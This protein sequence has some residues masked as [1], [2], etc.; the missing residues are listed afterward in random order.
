MVR[1]ELCYQDWIDLNGSKNGFLLKRLHE[2]LGQSQCRNPYRAKR[3]R[4]SRA[5]MLSCSVR[6]PFHISQRYHILKFNY[7]LFSLSNSR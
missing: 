5:A 2:A 4:L 6:N 7:I 3:H 1:S